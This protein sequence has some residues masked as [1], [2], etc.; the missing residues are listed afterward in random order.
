MC[1]LVKEHGSILKFKGKKRMKK[2]ETK[3]EKLQP[4][5]SLFG[6]KKNAKFEGLARFCVVTTGLERT[7]FFKWD[8]TISRAEV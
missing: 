8:G 4:Y 6:R 1:N 3:P 2:T 5:I 7:T